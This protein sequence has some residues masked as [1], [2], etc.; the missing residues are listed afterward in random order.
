MYSLKKP[1]LPLSKYR[2][3]GQLWL[4]AD[5]HLGPHAPK[6]A[7]AFYQFLAQAPEQT[8]NLI[9]CGDIFDAWIG[10]DV[11][12]SPE[13]W[14]AQAI[15]AL[16]DCGQRLNL[17][18]MR[19]NR[20]FLLGQRLASHVH[21]QLLPDETIIQCGDLRFL[22]THGDQY[23]TL[24][25]GYQRYR[26]WVHRSW[27][28]RAFLA[29][30]LSWRL[31]IGQRLRQHSQHKPY[32]QHISDI[33]PPSAEAALE[34]HQLSLLIHGHTHR[35]AIHRMGADKKRTRLVIPDWDYDHGETARGGWISVN[36][37]GKIGLHQSGQPSYYFSF[38]HPNHHETTAPI[39][40]K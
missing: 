8:D 20:D 11:I 36:P 24:D 2:M 4:A 13:P 27:L 14:L 35:P 22:L 21:A 32:V 30:P 16:Q 10:D 6:T 34:T 31:R 26:R 33:Y 9:L 19:G 3:R 29:L 40:H 28:Q 5:I 1:Q 7:A 18:L 17:Y 25:Q 12:S 39:S 37:Q 23:C 15:K 38:L